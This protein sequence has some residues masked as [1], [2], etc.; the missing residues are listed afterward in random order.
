M[1]PF[2]PHGQINIYRFVPLDETYQN[3]LHFPS[4]AAQLSYFGCV[5]NDTPVAPTADTVMKL[6]YTGQTFTRNE[7]QYI[8]IEANATM[9]YDCNYMAYQNRQFG[10]M[11]FFAFIHSVE[12]LGNNVCE[13]Y[14]EI[15]VMQSFMW[16]YELRECFVLRE[17]YCRADK[18]P[19]KAGECLQTEQLANLTYKTTKFDTTGYFEQFSVLALTAFHTHP[20]DNPQAM[21]FQNVGGLPMGGDTYTFAE[22]DYSNIQDALR[23]WVGAGALE[24]IVSLTLFPSTFSTSAS[25]PKTRNFRV[26]KP[27][28]VD[29]Y[30]PVNDR[31]FAY[32]FSFLIVDTGNND[33][34]YRYE[35]FDSDDECWFKFTASQGVQPQI[36]ITPDQYNMDS[37]GLSHYYNFTESI[38]MSNF[39]TLFFAGD[40]FANWFGQNATTLIFKGAVDVAQI[41]YGLG[42]KEPQAFVAGVSGAANELTGVLH[43]ANLPATAKSTGSAASAYVAKELDVAFKRTQVN[44]E[45]AR[46][47]D[48]YFTQYGYATNKVKVPNIR[49]YDRCRPDFNYIQCRE[50]SFHWD[51]YKDPQ[52]EGK[53][54]SVPQKYMKKIIEIYQKGITFWKNPEKVG[55]YGELKYHNNYKPNPSGYDPNA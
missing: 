14:F 51:E 43:A 10:S 5:D 45:A 47:A 16:N 35:F 29:G 15:D 42:A 8:R 3:T 24:G 50:M 32:P 38:I 37:G 20:F 41:A 2:I 34:T 13:V 33:A 18:Q 21:I 53:G 1:Q 36:R 39:P 11:W 12:Y 22:D 17:H 27:T 9:L 6:R 54:T 19:D 26:L 31:L 52:G 4:R 40:N 44:A 48:D 46:V 55:R 7:R 30:E 25:A 28:N 23:L 49:W